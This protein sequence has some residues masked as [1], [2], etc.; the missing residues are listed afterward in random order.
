MNIAILDDSKTASAKLVSLLKV[1]CSQHKITPSISVFHDGID[2]VVNYSGSF[3]IIYFDVKMPIMDGMTAAKKIRNIDNKV[4]IVFITNYVQWAI[5]G[6]SV[7]AADFLLKPVSSFG[8]KEHFTKLIRKFHSN[9]SQSYSLRTN[10]GLRK[11]L[12]SELLF[13]ESDGHYQV[14]HTTSNEYRILKPMK[15]VEEELAA[16]HFFRCHK[17]Y[18][19]NLKHVQKIEGNTLILHNHQ[20][21]I[22][23]PKRKAILSAWTSYMRGE[24]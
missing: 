4:I 21:Q 11:I 16:H 10:K 6:Y 15:E 3:D 12:L 13:I 23:R 7:D 17:G 8:F 22:S 20:L 2:L 19:V 14:F 18:L 9:Q 5:E 1:N 24:K